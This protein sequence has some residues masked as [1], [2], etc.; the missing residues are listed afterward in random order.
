MAGCGRGY[1]DR[2]WSPSF[3]PSPPRATSSSSSPLLGEGLSV[4]EADS[5]KA[6]V[7]YAWQIYGD[8]TLGS[9]ERIWSHA[10][11]M[12]VI[13]AGLKL[14][15]ESRMAAVLFAAADH[16]GLRRHQHRSRRGQSG[17]DEGAD[18][19][20]AQDAAGH[21]RGHP[22]RAAAPGQPHADPALLR[23][24]S[25]RTAR[26]GGAR[27][28]GTL[29]AAGQPPRRL[30]TEVG[31]GG[32]LLPLPAP[33]YLQEDR[34]ACSTRSAA[35]ASSSSSMP[36]SPAC[37]REAGGRRPMPR[38]MAGRSTSTASGTRCARR[39]SSSPRSTTCA[40]CA[41]S[42]TTSR[43]A[44]P[45]SA[46][47]TT[48]G[49]RSPRSSTTTSRIPRATTTARCTPP[50]AARTG[51]ALE[52]QIRTREMHKHAEL[53]VA[54]HWRYKEGSKRSAEDDYDEKIAWLRQLL[55]WKD[56]VADSARTGSST[57]SRPRSTRR[58]T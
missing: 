34:Q 7:E 33:G 16:Q 28:A 18:R 10:L 53:G 21:G 22:R 54:A 9:G 32:P 29:F 17:R 47:C 13:I 48:S 11:G 45:R 23:R 24:Q 19:S 5:L 55:T 6:A 57:T 42:S 51:A 49:R 8:K 56:E 46:S 35:S 15:V 4:A 2:L 40:P 43:T 20:A 50:C 39:A 12:A 26:P 36:W 30:G 38:S 1:N 58:S 27:D 3:I 44:T 31:A 37:K 14:D 52:V 25:G 41:S